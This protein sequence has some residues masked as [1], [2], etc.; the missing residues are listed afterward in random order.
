MSVKHLGETFDIHGGGRDLI[1][2]HHENEIAQS[3]ACNG[4]AFARYWIHNG[5]VNIDAEKMSKSLNN[6]LTI[7]DVLARYP[8]EVL[9]MF[10]LSAHYRSPLDY[11]EQNF[12]H[13][14]AAL[15]RYYVT[16][17][18]LEECSAQASGTECETS[19]LERV[20]VLRAEFRQAMGD[21]FNT[22][23]VMGG[24]FE[25]VR[26]WNK[27]LDEGLPVSKACFDAFFDAVRDIHSVLGIFGSDAGVFLDEMKSKAVGAKG[28]NAAEIESLITERKTARAA[29]DFKR[30]D[31]IRDRLKD[32]GVILKDNPDG[33]TTWTAG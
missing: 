7:R 19:L 11:T 4:K 2:P 18:R 27:T 30:S 28:V 20:N 12:Q 26:E 9:R 14:L 3:E 5:F 29:K 13:A 17:R 16:K 15:E 23:K 32:Q 31:E 10:I 6:F 1:F 25:L 33:T 8:S 22:A 21:D 24:I